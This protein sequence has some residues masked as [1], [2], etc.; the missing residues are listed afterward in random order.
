MTWREVLD[1]WSQFHSATRDTQQKV[2]EAMQSQFPG[3]YTIQ[4]D[5][6]RKR[7]TFKTRYGVTALQTYYKLV[8]D[9]PEDETWF[10]LK[11]T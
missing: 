6:N 2:I 7:V 5:D 8:F 3:N 11:Y 9:T 4:A 1:Y 10:H